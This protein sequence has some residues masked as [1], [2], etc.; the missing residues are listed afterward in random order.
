MIE[1]PTV[2][3]ECDHCGETIEV[4]PEYRYRSYS[5]DSGYFNC[6]E[7]AIV[8]LLKNEDWIANEDRQ[9]CSQKCKEEQEEE[10]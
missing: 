7:K 10:E 1:E 3:V 6:S 5:P 4:K 9:Y 2:V 8:A